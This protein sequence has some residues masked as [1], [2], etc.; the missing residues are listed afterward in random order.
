LRKKVERLKLKKKHESPPNYAN[1]PF[2]LAKKKRIGHFFQVLNLV[3][4]G[5]IILNQ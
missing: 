3:L 1:Q 5:F 2:I 4:G